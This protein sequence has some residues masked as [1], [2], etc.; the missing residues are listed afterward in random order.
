M[1]DVLP[2][3]VEIEGAGSVLSEDDR[4]QFLRADR[5]QPLVGPGRQAREV[6]PPGPLEYGVDAYGQRLAF[7][8]PAL[9]RKP[10]GS[11]QTKSPPIVSPR[12]SPSNVQAS[13]VAKTSGSKRIVIPSTLTKVV[14]K[15]AL[16][17]AKHGAK[18]DRHTNVPETNPLAGQ[19][20][21]SMSTRPV[22]LVAVPI[23]SAE[24]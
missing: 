13:P 17:T 12:S 15:M 18:A 20:M 22:R 1:G 9:T 10:N 7:H 4:R 11:T 16:S 2:Q 19:I 8:V 24:G 3:R 21:N 23:Q 14:P 5:V 6:P